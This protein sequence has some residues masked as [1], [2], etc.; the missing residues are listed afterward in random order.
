MY[1]T[2]EYFEYNKSAMGD[3]ISLHTK[4]T[5]LG[6][7]MIVG[8]ANLDVRSYFMDTNNAIFIRNAYDLNR[9]Y[10]QYIDRLTSDPKT[11]IS[12]TNYFSTLS[13]DRIQA[14]NRE[15]LKISLARWD[16]KGRINDKRQNWILEE[17][18]ELGKRISGDT[19]TLL[20][21]RRIIDNAQYEDPHAVSETEKELNETANRFD[22]FFKLL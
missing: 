17:F 5:L 4:L 1:P 10:T 3:G 22:D 19:Q 2:L 7:D 14:E 8:S 11:T 15:I 16:K 6:N 12:K 21:F 9:E 18:T 13:D 20:D